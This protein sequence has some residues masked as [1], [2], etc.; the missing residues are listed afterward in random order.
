MTFGSLST[1]GGKVKTYL[2]QGEIT[3]DPIPPDFFGCCGVAHVENL[4]EVLIHIGRH[5]HRH[6]MSMTS[7][8][9][10]QPVKEAF[11]QYLG[12]EVALPQGY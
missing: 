4:Q 9:V 5:S 1:D 7:G 12:F 3:N 8:L 10:V 6:H 2:G 11:E